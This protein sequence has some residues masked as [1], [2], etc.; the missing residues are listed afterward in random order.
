MK[1]NFRKYINCIVWIF[2]TTYGY[3]YSVIDLA[4]IVQKLILGTYFFK[5]FIFRSR[6]IRLQIA[7]NLLEKSTAYHS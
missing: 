3:S 4:Y 2:N 5:D 1:P 7:S 6:S